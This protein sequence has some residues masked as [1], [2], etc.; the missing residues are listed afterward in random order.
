MTCTR[1]SDNGM[2]YTIVIDYFD[3][4]TNR[5]Y[6]LRI[7]YMEQVQGRFLSSADYILEIERTKHDYLPVSNEIGLISLVYV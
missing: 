5:L 7:Y 6:L 1:T 2:M 3:L 4:K